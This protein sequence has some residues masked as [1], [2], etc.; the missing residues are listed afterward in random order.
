VADVGLQA[1]D[2]QD[3]PLLSLQESAQTL[4][5]GGSQGAEFVVAVEQVGDG[6]LGNG[7]A[8]AAELLM[9]FGDTPMFGIAEA[10]DEGNDIQAKFVV[11]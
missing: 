7:D 2:G 6:T 4:G 10:A 5:G 3:H 1:V 11:R 9:D 8:T